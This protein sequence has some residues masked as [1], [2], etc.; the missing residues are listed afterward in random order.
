MESQIQSEELTTN[1]AIE[2]NG[3]YFDKWIG[4]DSIS[5]AL[6]GIDNNK[7]SI[8]D[9]LAVYDLKKGK[10]IFQAEN[11]EE[12]YDSIKLLLKKLKESK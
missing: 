8:E 1:H 3:L 6:Y 2:E 5:S 4:L 11:K 12:F 7:N 10:L 9:L